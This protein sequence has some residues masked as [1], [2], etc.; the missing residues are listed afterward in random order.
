LAWCDK[1]RGSFD[2]TKGAKAGL[3]HGQEKDVTRTELRRGADS[4]KASLAMAEVVVSGLG[5]NVSEVDSGDS[6]GIFSGWSQSAK[7]RLEEAL[8]GQP[9]IASGLQVG[10]ATIMADGIHIDVGMP[11]TA[12]WAEGLSEDDI[13]HAF[14]SEIYDGIQA[15]IDHTIVPM[16]PVRKQDLH[17]NILK[18]SAGLGKKASLRRAAGHTHTL[19]IHTD[20]WPIKETYAGVVVFKQ[21]EWRGEAKMVA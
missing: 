19:V 1:C 12:G 9:Y 7:A 17:I 18:I 20:N 21:E 2:Y 15:L 5:I 8:I 16:T 3:R 13:L 11:Y 4:E 6:G 14:E 10:S